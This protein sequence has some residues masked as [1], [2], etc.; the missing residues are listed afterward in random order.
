[1]ARAGACLLATLL[2]CA[3]GPS[4]QERAERRALTE[5]LTLPLPMAT[6][7]A[8]WQGPALTIED[9][10][11]RAVALPLDAGPAPMLLAALVLEPQAPTQAGVLVAHGHYGRGKNDANALQIAWRLARAGARVVV[12]DSPGVEEWDVAGR[13]IHLAEGA[14]G[15]AFLAA[16]GTSALALQVQALRRGL[17]LLEAL[18]ARRLG[19]TG[20]SGGAVLGF[21]LGLVDPRVQVLALAAVPPIPREARAAGCPCDQLPGRPGP[22]PTLLAL[23]DLPLL[24]LSDQ[25]QPRPEGLPRGVDFEVHE[26]DHAFTEEMQVRALDHLA[27][28]LPLRRSPGGQ[29][30]PLEPVPALELHSPGAAAD[31]TA[32]AL[33]DLGWTATAAPWRPAP[34]L[35]APYELD[36]A[37]QGPLVLTAG[38]DPADHAALIGA[39]LTACAVRV[40]PDA[41]ALAQA[42]SQ[43]R[44]AADRPAGALLRA[45]RQRGALGIYAVRAWA[46]PA[47]ATGLP[48]VVR[49]PVLQPQQV[50]P[51]RDPAWIH[52]P[53]AWWGAT[54]AL[55][56]RAA[57][58]GSQPEAL[59]RALAQLVGAAP[60][61]APAGEEP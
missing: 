5:A 27:R 54:Q 28:H 32:P 3:C 15:R 23:A 45:A 36:C 18:G 24:W 38:A 4:E 42:I 47:L 41:A 10:T 59:A 49:D 39:G 21:Y 48:V 1:M 50:D 34:D 35:D 37:G 7:G 6:G 8:T 55:L 46:M 22:D 60:T 56:D 26:G 16:V 20:A 25:S 53:G 58:T 2:L 43:G 9:V 12:L 61:V 31:P 30:R 17:D 57:A 14:H 44:A 52:V 19:A 11:A 29:D 51:A 33:W 40:P 13:R